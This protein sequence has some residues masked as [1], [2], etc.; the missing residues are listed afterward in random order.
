VAENSASG[1]IIYIV[2]IKTRVENILLKK[3]SDDESE[4]ENL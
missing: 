3:M 2:V 4:M 1:K